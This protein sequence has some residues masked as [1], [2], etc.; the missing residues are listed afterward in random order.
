MGVK[1][2][3]TFACDELSFLLSRIRHCDTPRCDCSHGDDMQA[4][5]AD[6][7]NQQRMMGGAL[8][9]MRKYKMSQVVAF[10]AL[11]SLV[12]LPCHPCHLRSPFLSATHVCHM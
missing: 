10:L 7:K 1:E 9:R 4:W 5:Y 2:L 3:D 6:Y 8:N 11:L 12:T